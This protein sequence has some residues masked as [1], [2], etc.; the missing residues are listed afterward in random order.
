MRTGRE[1][2]R[3]AVLRSPATDMTFPPPSFSRSTAAPPQSGPGRPY[4]SE[5][6]SQRPEAEE[7]RGLDLVQA[8]ADL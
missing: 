3:A 6:P 8:C 4:T 1:Q 5:R 7:G 2:V